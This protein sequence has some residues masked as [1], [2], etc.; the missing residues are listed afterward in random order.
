M[1][2]PSSRQEFSA[3]MVGPVLSTSS[4]SE[5][6]NWLNTH[7][8]S[9]SDVRHVGFDTESEIFW[10]P[11]RA[12]QL[13]LIQIAVA[14]G[15]V[16]LIDVMC[17]DRPSPALV[18]LLLDDCVEKCCIGNDEPELRRYFPSL[19]PLRQVMDVQYLAQIKIDR[20]R[21]PLLSTQALADNYVPQLGFIKNKQL[22]TS[23]W[24]R[25]PLSAAQIK[26]AADDARIALAIRLA[27]LE[28]DYEALRAM[29]KL[30][31]EE[32]R[33]IRQL[34]LQEQKLRREQ[35]EEEYRRQRDQ[36]EV[37]KQRQQ[38]IMRERQQEA[39]QQAMRSNLSCDCTFRNQVFAEGTFR[40]CYLGEY[41]S[42]ARKS[43]PC[44]V[45]VFRSGSVFQDDF[46]RFDLQAVDKA[47]DIVAR[48]NLLHSDLKPIFVN[49]A[50]VWTQSEGHQK[51]QRML[52]EPF[53][54]DW[55]RFNSNSGWAR[56][57]DSSG[58]NGI[59]QALSHFSY[60]V[61]GGQLLLCDLQGG[62]TRQGLVLSDPVIHSR[63]GQR[64][65]GVTD[66]GVNGINT[67]FH[68]HRC[69]ER[70]R[71]EWA[72][73]RD[74]YAAYPLREGSTM[75]KLSSAAASSSKNTMQSIHEDEGEDDYCY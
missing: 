45:K 7:I 66:L 20:G 68:R 71:P 32:E 14:S 4:A 12:N 36:E 23:D 50:T 15:A 26:Y 57:G 48:W 43:Q 59:A 52:V 72:Q 65:F 56:K 27:Q 9:R 54:R 73:P 18:R 29:A 5:V 39:K 53:I 67:F 2:A 3:S 19:S 24:G 35:E 42:G 13:S 16:L 40:L 6:G 60:H 22:T 33:R 41:S 17:W 28:D 51:G 25:R 11:G 30:Q 21:A 74:T 10:Q 70:C 37:Q 58:W 62:S 63:G 47:I 1:A 44:V 75:Q 46:F 49:T 31:E 8:F 38:H 55:Q 34:E 61:T 64:V 69:T